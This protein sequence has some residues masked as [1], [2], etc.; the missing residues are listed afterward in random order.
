MDTNTTAHKHFYLCEDTHCHNAHTHTHTHTHYYSVSAMH[1]LWSLFF[2]THFTLHT[3]SHTQHTLYYQ[4]K[5]NA[6]LV[7]LSLSVTVALTIPAVSLCTSGFTLHVSLCFYCSTGLYLTCSHY[8]RGQS[9]CK[10][11]PPPCYDAC[12]HVTYTVFT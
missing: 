11:S 7:T 5:C 1:F 9:L 12:C 6:P 3:A 10:S 4:C 2:V 8:A